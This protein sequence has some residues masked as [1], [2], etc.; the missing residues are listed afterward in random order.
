M[1]YQTF[2]RSCSYAGLANML[3]DYYIDTEDYKIIKAADIPYIFQ[4]DISEDKFLAGPMLQGKKYFDYYLKPI[5][6]EFR[7]E[8]IRRK[9]II[10]FLITNERRAMI[11]LKTDNGLGHAFIYTGTEKNRLKFINNKWERSDEPD[12]YIYDNQQLLDRLEDESF[13]GWIEEISTSITVNSAPEIASSLIFLEDYRNRL[14]LFCDEEQN[15]ESLAKAKHNLFEALFLDVLSMMGIIEEFEIAHEIKKV[16]SDYI[17]IMKL[18]TNAVLS[19]VLSI[20]SLENI[21]LKYIKL[22]EQRLNK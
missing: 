6:F 9:D 18:R 5:G 21:I 22:I 8:K 14:R 15:V 13:V 20:N 10:E 11:G 16:R 7:E 3:M 2:N 1:K 19:E 17:N 4:Y 12:Y